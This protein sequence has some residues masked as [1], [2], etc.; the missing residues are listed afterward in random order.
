MRLSLNQTY[1]WILHLSDDEL[2]VMQT[3]LRGDE[4]S[5]EDES[6]ADH[7]SA[8]L[9]KIRPFAERDRERRDRF[10]TER[11][12]RYGDKRRNVVINPNNIVIPNRVDSSR[13]DQSSRHLR[14]PWQRQEELNAA[15]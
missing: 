12:E 2:T 6:K 15:E 1:P 5:D 11:K 8:T 3:V 9:D 4:L 13:G 10:Y 14:P 7:L